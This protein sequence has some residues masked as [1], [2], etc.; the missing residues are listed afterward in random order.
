MLEDK[1]V[2]LDGSKIHYIESGN[3]MPFLFVH[4]ARFNARTYEETGT[5]D[6]V[7]NAGFHAI[8][9]DFPGYGKSENMDIDLSGFIAK[10]I[11]TMKL[12]PGVVLGASMGGEAVV[13]FAVKYPEKFKALVLTGAVG[14]S[15]YEDQLDKISDKPMLLI[16]GKNDIVSPINNYKL[17][18][19][20]NKNAE[21][22]NVGRQHACY[23]DDN[24]S[25]NGYIE[26]FLKKIK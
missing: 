13:G 12:E 6:T 26:E 21:F 7:S 18:M 5:I 23:L 17:L 11:D 14:V 2:D 1:F 24:K 15:S 3:G 19:K 25:F 8:S 22:Y 20:H 16:W 4:G 9:L 10:F